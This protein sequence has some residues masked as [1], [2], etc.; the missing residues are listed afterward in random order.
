MTVLAEADALLKDNKPLDAIELLSAVSSEQDLS[1]E[2]HYLLGVAYFLSDQV[3]LAEVELVRA[4]ELKSDDPRA[5]FYLGRCYESEGDRRLAIEMYRQIVTQPGSSPD[6]IR[7]LE[8]LQKEHESLS[9]NPNFTQTDV[10]KLQ[11]SQDQEVQRE[12]SARVGQSEADIEY[13]KG[14]RSL[15]RLGFESTSVESVQR[16]ILKTVTGIVFVS[17]I[18]GVLIA[19]FIVWLAIS[20]IWR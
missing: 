5:I 12:R 3:N 9:K 7:R 14:Q 8:R 17:L 1:F 20:V 13:A 4:R 11:V 18:L 16:T 15:E 6:L 10:N 2:F 19:C